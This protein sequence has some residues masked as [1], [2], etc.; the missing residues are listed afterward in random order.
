MGRLAK[1]WSG[2]RGGCSRGCSRL[3]SRPA[4]A[5]ST[6]D[7]ERRGTALLKTCGRKKARFDEA[8][9]I[10]LLLDESQ[11]DGLIVSPRRSNPTNNVCLTYAAAI[12]EIAAAANWVIEDP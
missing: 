7:C 3:F 1:K 11:G 10:P 2:R 4:L 6:L 12:V 9:L 8:G 5:G